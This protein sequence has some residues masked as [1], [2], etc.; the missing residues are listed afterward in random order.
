M[1]KKV[2]GEEEAKEEKVEV[3]KSEE[4]APVVEMLVESPVIKTRVF[5]Q[6]RAGICEFHGTPYG[7][8]DTDTCKGKCSHV[9]ASDPL[10]P[11]SRVGCE[12]DF[13]EGETYCRH[14][15]SY[16]NLPIRCTYCPLDVDVRGVLKTRTFYIFQSPNDPKKLIMVCSDYRCT[17]KHQQRFQQQVI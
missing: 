11:H 13:R 9:C 3:P 15:H 10:C 14:E 12:K 5:P 4:E 8:V 16:K 6:I 2:E 7:K 17:T 1:K